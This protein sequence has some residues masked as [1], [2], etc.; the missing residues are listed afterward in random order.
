MIP[1]LQILVIQP[2]LEL[3]YC[4]GLDMDHIENQLMKLARVVVYSNWHR[5]VSRQ[6]L[7]ALLNDPV[8]KVRNLNFLIFHAILLHSAFGVHF[9]R[10]SFESA[11]E[12]FDLMAKGSDVPRLPMLQKLIHRLN[13]EICI[14]LQIAD[15]K[16]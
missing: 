13:F 1:H 7:L 12:H 14:H 2:E 11:L 9:L 15:I 4:H 6:N 3:G 16:V 8:Q 10:N 5:L